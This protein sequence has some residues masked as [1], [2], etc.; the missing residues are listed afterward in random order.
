MIDPRSQP[1][2]VGLLF[3]VLFLFGFWSHAAQA[4]P[5]WKQL[6]GHSVC[7]G[8]T[9]NGQL[10]PPCGFEAARFVSKAVGKCSPG[11]FF[12]IGTWSCYSCPTGYNRNAKAVTSEKACDRKVSKQSVAAE[13]LGKKQCPPGTFMDA[14]NGG[15]CWTCPPGYGRTAAG[16]DKWNACGKVMKKAVSAT[17]KGSACPPGS[18]TDPRN[19]GECWTCPEGFNRTAN[20]VTGTRACV[21]VLEFLPAQKIEALTC[22]AG[23]HFDFIDGGTCWS[24]PPNFIRTVYGVKTGK[25]CETQEMK[26]ATPT[27]DMPGLFGLSSAIEDMALEL[28]K[29][30]KEIDAAIADG[31]SQVTGAKLDDVKKT[32][33]L[34][35]ENEPWRSDILPA[36]I[37]SKIL[38]AARKPVNQQTAVEKKILNDLGNQIQWNRQFIA[39]QTRQAFDVWM[40]TRTA[41]QAARSKNNMTMFI[42]AVATPPDFNK[43]VSATVQAGTMATT[44]G[45][46]VGTVFFAKSFKL[47]APYAGKGSKVATVL[48]KIATP[49]GKVAVTGSRLASAAAGPA[50]TAVTT[51]I[52]I[53]MELDKYIKIEAT[54]GKIRQAEKIASQP[55]D[56][57]LL[58]QEKNG[59]DQFL[60][61]WMAL[62][63]AETVPSSTFRAKLAA[64][65]AGGSSPSLPQMPTIIG[66]KPLSGA[67]TSDAARLS[68]TLASQKVQPKG[69]FRFEF[70]AVPGLCMVQQNNTAQTIA[71]GDCRA[72]NTPWLV[73][74]ARTKELVIADDYCVSIDGTASGPATPV[75]IQKC[76]STK[77]KAW[78]LESQGQIRLLRN[79]PR[80]CLDVEDAKP[81]IGAQVK[82]AGC[83]VKKIQ[84]QTWR[85]WVPAG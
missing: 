57:G 7:G 85:L 30:R 75:L 29:D 73:P 62:T 59:E 2:Q 43:I 35:L 80:M 31:T 78:A 54:E 69:G 33:W 41:D 27:R 23:D 3:I 20:S 83:K 1:I 14:R 5:N 18:F 32:A 17:F 61:H 40:K 65:Q 74:D 60:F 19:G 45:S 13:F 70:S 22:K 37:V 10:Q 58:L 53:A 44:L 79:G 76:S 71:L 50:L 26:W 84:S 77:Q 42:G 15:E 21:Q 72:Q 56:I 6:Q 4:N 39:A 8:I 51:A 68:A 66:G 46:G 25:A 55:A 48:L 81:A 34:L 12:D 63:N 36:V 11:S 28:I 82:L 38:A 49:V 52:T 67:I 24:C 64:L 9:A 16:V 47:L